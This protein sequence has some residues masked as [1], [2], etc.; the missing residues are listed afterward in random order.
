MLHSLFHDEVFH[1]GVFHD[2]VFHD[3]TSTMRRPRY[4]VS[5]ASVSKPT[6]DEDEAQ[7]CNTRKIAN[8]EQ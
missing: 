1:D 8:S 7:N 2:G 4:A 5:T 3:E 6:L